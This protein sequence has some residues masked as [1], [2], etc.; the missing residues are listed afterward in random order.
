MKFEHISAYYSILFPANDLQIRFLSSA[1]NP[2]NRIFADI[3]CG[4]GQQAAALSAEGCEVWGLDYEKDMI[5]SARSSH[6]ET[7]ER[8]ILGDM[9]EADT[10]LL[11]V[12]PAQPGTVYCIGNSLVQFTDD[13]DIALSLSSFSRLLPSGGTLVIQTVN[14]A[15]IILGGDFS[16]PLL[17]RKIPE[18]GNSV[19]LARE[20]TCSE[21]EECLTF[22]TVLSSPEGTVEKNHD[23]RALGKAE[24]EIMLYESGFS[25]LEFY[26][27]YD[28]SPWSETSPATIVTAEK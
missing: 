22:R 16:F 23:L 27:N 28:R 8:F 20:Y 5:D 13:E 10:V 4:T 17:E 2:D 26:G 19:T 12:M 21:C 7:A 18:T 1:G 15:R 6:P 3:A 24:L 9:R 14:F 25:C 11:P